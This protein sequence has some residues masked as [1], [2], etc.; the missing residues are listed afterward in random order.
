MPF[1]LMIPQTSQ[2]S[3][4]FAFMQHAWFI[5]KTVW[6][7][8]LIFKLMEKCTKFDRVLAV[9]EHFATTAPRR[10]PAGGWSISQCPAVVRVQEDVELWQSAARAPAA[11]P[12]LL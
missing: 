10:P 1:E 4:A 7:K 3:S 12:L 5:A 2:S 8:L 6:Q 9:Q 11:D